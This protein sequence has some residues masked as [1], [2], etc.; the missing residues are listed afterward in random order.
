[1]KCE[2]RNLTNGECVQIVVLHEGWRYRRLRERFGISHTSVSRMMERYKETGNHSRR[3]GQ[4]RRRVTK[5]V[6]D[7]FLRLRILRQRYVTTRSLQSKLEDVHNVRISCRTVR[8]RLKE[9]N[10]FLTSLVNG[11]DKRFLDL[12]QGI[13]AVSAATTPFFEK[14]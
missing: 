11:W 10:L 5:P 4:G 12:Y 2:S 8:Q 7:R 1:M 3:P 13:L 6:Q 9:G 14:I